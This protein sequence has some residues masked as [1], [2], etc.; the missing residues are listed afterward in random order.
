[1]KSPLSRMARLAGVKVVPLK[2]WP[3]TRMAWAEH[4]FEQWYNNGR[5]D[6]ETM[7]YWYLFLA[8]DA[9]EV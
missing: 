3:Q 4:Y 1:M 7:M 5:A 8:T 6:S 2:G 9:N